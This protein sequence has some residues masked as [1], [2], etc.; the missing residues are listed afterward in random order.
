VTNDGAIFHDPA[1]KSS[2]VQPAHLRPNL[3]P[4]TDDYSNLFQILK[5]RD[6]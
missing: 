4:W 6:K 2:S 3:R 1:F 5:I